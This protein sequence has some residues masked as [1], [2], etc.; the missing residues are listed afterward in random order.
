MRDIVTREQFEEWAEAL[1]I[2]CVGSSKLLGR[3]LDHDAA[4]R[5]RVEAMERERAMYKTIAADNCRYADDRLNVIEEMATEV[6]DLT[7]RLA[8]AQ[9]ITAQEARKG[10]PGATWYETKPPS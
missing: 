2:G 9:P 6:A 4:L 7:A 5:A 8:A 1:Q 10:E 3:L